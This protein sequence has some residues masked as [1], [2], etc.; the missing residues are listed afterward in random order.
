MLIMWLTMSACI[1]I[2]HYC[3][4]CSQQ[5]LWSKIGILFL[6]NLLQNYLIWKAGRE[7]AKRR[8]RR[9]EGERRREKRKEEIVHLLIHL[10]VAHS[11]WV[12]A[13]LKPGPQNSIWCPYECQKPK[14]LNHDLM[15]TRVCISQSL[16][17]RRSAV[18]Y[19]CQTV[20]VLVYVL[21]IVT[22]IHLF[23]HTSS[24]KAF[25]PFP[26]V[27]NLWAL[28]QASFSLAIVRSGSLKTKIIP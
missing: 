20:Y 5:I 18:G 7:R 25:K 15:P 12:W 8:D 3:Y 24:E 2:A 28:L 26:P 27:S 13:R 19:R 6:N 4:L 14:H 22:N 21:V 17:S 9:D 23:H 1:S 16:K 10:L 11:I